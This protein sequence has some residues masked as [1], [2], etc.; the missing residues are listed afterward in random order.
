MVKAKKVGKSEDDMVPEDTAGEGRS[1]SVDGSQDDATFEESLEEL[2]ALV[3][4]LERGQLLLDESLEL[5]ERGMK[6]ARVCN[7][8]L[9]KAERKIEMLIE[10]NGSLKVGPF[11]EE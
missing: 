5:F 10:E 1:D 2:E 11:M 6:L 7:R 3:D 9:S 4:R 8:K